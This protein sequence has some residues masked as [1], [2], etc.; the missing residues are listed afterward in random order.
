MKITGKEGK[1]YSD[2]ELA[3]RQQA[4]SLRYSEDPAYTSW[5]ILGNRFINSLQKVEGCRGLKIVNIMEEDGQTGIMLVPVDKSGNE[6]PFPEPE[7][8]E[9]G[10]TATKGD[11]PVPKCP[12]TCN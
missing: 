8:N 3:Q 7:E 1:Y 6:L 12:F 2:V 10:E 11:P 5:E 9:D 4:Y